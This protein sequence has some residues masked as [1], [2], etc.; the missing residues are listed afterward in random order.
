[1]SRKLTPDEKAFI[2]EITLKLPIYPV[3]DKDNQFT[4]KNT[5][6]K[7]SQ[8]LELRKQS[9]I[10]NKY[11]SSYK[12]IQPGKTYFIPTT[13][14]TVP[15]IIFKNILIKWGVKA[16]PAELEKYLEEHKRV[17]KILLDSNASARD[18]QD[19]SQP[20]EDNNPTEENS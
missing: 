6:M 18:K 17:Q 11:D 3:L 10:K 19:S 20:L 1:M 5:P 8:L 9:G 2:E 7:G 15:K 13:I 12:K 16:I 14:E 4:Y